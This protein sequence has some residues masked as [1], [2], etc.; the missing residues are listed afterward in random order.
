VVPFPWGTGVG[1]GAFEFV[2]A[3]L[4]DMWQKITMHKQGPAKNQLLELF[5]N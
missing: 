4:Q 3:P 1:G 5:R 2:L